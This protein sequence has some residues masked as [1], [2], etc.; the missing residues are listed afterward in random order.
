M[1]DTDADT[2]ATG[3]DAELTDERLE[4]AL[5][6]MTDRV[7]ATLAETGD[8]F[9]FVADPDTGEWE[10]TDDGNWCGGHWVGLLWT[11]R[12]VA[13]EAG[14]HD[15]AR[16]FER[17]AYDHTETLYEAMPRDW[18]FCGMNFHYAGFLGYDHTGDRDLY[19]VGLAG[20]DAMV[21]MFDEAARQIRVGEHRI[22]G[23]EKQF[24]MEREVEGRPAGKHVAVLDTVYTSLPVLWR[25]YRET[26][27]TRFRD[28]ALAHADRH[29]D[30]YLDR[31]GGNVHMAAY[32]PDTGEVERFFDTLAH[33]DDTTWARGQGWNVAGL[34]AA[35]SETGA[36][37]FLDFLEAAVDYYLEHTPEDLV[38]YWDFEDPRIPDVPRDTS[39]AALTAYGLT[40]LEGEDDRVERLRAVGRDIAASLVSEYLL[41][42]V[43]DDRR[44]MVLHGCYNMPGNYATDNELVWTDFY[45]ART[46]WR[47]LDRER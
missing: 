10:T 41:T 20:A 31:E 17:A 37:R 44:G 12:E 34:S 28:V 32:D 43:D 35:Y 7:G 46:L 36:R 14:E 15:R 1:D 3:I 21:E 25:A 9:P 29:T 26:G 27:H 19:A 6:A 2:D 33:D 40:G 23:P 16:R 13:A 4:A 30:W 11:A 47:L 39:S 8:R 45:V 18:M 22:K 38:P 5:S 42:D 24:D